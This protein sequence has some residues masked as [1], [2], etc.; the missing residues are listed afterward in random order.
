MSGDDR[1]F[2]L[3]VAEWSLITTDL[4]HARQ[5]L[6]TLQK[7][8]ASDFDSVVIR[9]ALT[10]SAIVAYCR[11]FK[12]SRNEEKAWK[13]WIPKELV[14]DLPDELRQLHNQLMLDRD[15]AWAHTDWEAH[16]PAVSEMS[17]GFEIRSRNVWVPL[18]QSL[19]TPFLKLIYEV[20]TR[21]LPASE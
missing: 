18:D 20:E 7:V 2:K 15:Q 21:L 13:R 17:G 8:A 14:D 5:F 12:T 16:R 4:N 1:I 11:P 9:E 3:S 10:L 19:I 6:W